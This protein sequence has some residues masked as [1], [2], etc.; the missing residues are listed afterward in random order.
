MLFFPYKNFIRNHSNL[1]FY[2]NFVKFLTQFWNNFLIKHKKTPLQRHFRAA[3]ICLHHFAI[4]CLDLR[5]QKFANFW[6]FIIYYEQS[7]QQQQQQ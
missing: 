3:E 5:Q 1:S 6:H 7:I 4:V 2:F